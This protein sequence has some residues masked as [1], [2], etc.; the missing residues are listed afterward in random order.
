MLMVFLTYSFQCTPQDLHLGAEIEETFKRITDDKR[1][2]PMV[3]E[4]RTEMEKNVFN[5]LFI[6]N[7]LFFLDSTILPYTFYF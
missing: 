7:Y 6:I 5:F 4:C 3:K 2:Y 1:F